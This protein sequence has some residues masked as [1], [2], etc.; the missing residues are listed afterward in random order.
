[1]LDFGQTG[2]GTIERDYDRSGNATA[3]RQ[4]LSGVGGLSGSGQQ[5]FTYDAANRLTDSTFGGT[6]GS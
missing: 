1:V 6:E 3:E 5:T 2:A 4:S